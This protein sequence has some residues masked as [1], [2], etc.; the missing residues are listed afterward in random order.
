MRDGCYHGAPGF[1]HIY[2]F[3]LLRAPFAHI[4]LYTTICF[5]KSDL[6]HNMYPKCYP[7]PLK[8]YSQIAIIFCSV[9]LSFLG[10][11]NS[12]SMCLGHANAVQ[13]TSGIDHMANIMGEKIVRKGT[14]IHQDNM[15]RTSHQKDMETSAA[16]LE[17]VSKMCQKWCRKG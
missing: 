6:R 17:N 16:Y 7:N 4:I 11:L 5:K 12:Q 9:F 15:T 3:H 14:Q 1:P 13:I 2:S 10:A 8:M